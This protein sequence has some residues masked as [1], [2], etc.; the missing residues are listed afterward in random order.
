MTQ[1]LNSDC[2]KIAL[3]MSLSTKNYY[4]DN[5]N[6]KVDS[7]LRGIVWIGPLVEGVLR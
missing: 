5:R 2:H 7:K 1:A 4:Y 3:L 6:Y